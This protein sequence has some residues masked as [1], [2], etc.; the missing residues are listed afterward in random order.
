MSLKVKKPGNIEIEGTGAG[1]KN[2][3][4]NGL[5]YEEN[6]EFCDENV[7][8]I[9]EIREKK[10]KNKTKEPIKLIFIIDINKTILSKL[11]KGVF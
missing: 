5:S 7:V 6:T 11:I 4:K 2:T 1:G 10:K 8:K 9:L 3:N